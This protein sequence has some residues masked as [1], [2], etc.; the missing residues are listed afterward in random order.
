MGRD[1]AILT[2]RWTVSRIKKANE[3]NV[4]TNSAVMR[5]SIR[6]DPAQ[7]IDEFFAKKKKKKK[8]QREEKKLKQTLK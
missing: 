2:A 1:D 8:R 3:M 5:D 6:E 4:G 7:K